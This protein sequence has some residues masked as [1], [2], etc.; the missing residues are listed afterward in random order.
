KAQEIRI[1]NYK[2]IT[3][4]AE[5]HCLQPLCDR[6]VDFVMSEHTI[7]PS[8]DVFEIGRSGDSISKMIV[9]TDKP[10]TKPLKLHFYDVSKVD[11]NLRYKGIPYDKLKETVGLEHFKEIELEVNATGENEY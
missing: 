7:N 1:K 10:L 11:Q 3:F 8:T 2:G 4:P 6:N 5:K 9:T